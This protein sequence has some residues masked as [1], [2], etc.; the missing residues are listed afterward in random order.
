MRVV[1]YGFFF[2]DD[3][4]MLIFFAEKVVF[5]F[6]SVFKCCYL[7]YRFFVWIEFF[8]FDGIVR[9]EKFLNLVFCLF[10]IFFRAVSILIDLFCLKVF[11]IRIVILNKWF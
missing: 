10:F 2:G 7:F 6:V 11:E 3:A 4:Y 8:V 5:E 1:L 9:G